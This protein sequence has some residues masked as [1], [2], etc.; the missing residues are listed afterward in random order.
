ML[1]DTSIELYCRPVLNSTS[2]HYP[3]PSAKS[4]GRLRW[5]CRPLR[6]GIVTIRGE[7]VGL[8]DQASIRATAISQVARDSRNRLPATMWSSKRIGVNLVWRAFSAKLPPLHSQRHIEAGQRFLLSQDACKVVALHVESWPAK[9]ELLPALSSARKYVNDSA[10]QQSTFALQRSRVFDFVLAMRRSQCRRP[11]RAQLQELLLHFRQQDDVVP[12]TLTERRVARDNLR[13]D[14]GNVVMLKERKQQ[15]LEV[16]KSDGP[17]I[18]SPT[19]VSK[20]KKV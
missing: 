10:A 1:V 8:A 2:V 9:V 11:A 4:L 14:G 18:R 16:A 15:L 6:R 20:T 3:S 7:C 17:S 13:T 19:T 12:Q 5:L